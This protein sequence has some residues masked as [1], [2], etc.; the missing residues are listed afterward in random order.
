MGISTIL[1]REFPW[2][3]GQMTSQAV[4]PDE[5]PW[6]ESFGRT[7]LYSEYRS[8]VRASYQG[9]GMTPEAEANPHLNPGQGWVSRL[10]HEPALGVRVLEQMI[11]EAGRPTMLPGPVS[12]VEMSGDRVSAVETATHRIEGRFFL[13]ATELGD[14]L[15]LSGAESVV[16]AESRADT[17]EPNALDGPAEPRCQQG[18]TWCAVFGWDPAGD[19]TIAK[20]DQYERWRAFSPPGWPGPLLGFEY[21]NVQTGETTSLPLFGDQPLTWFT[22]RQIVD[23]ALWKEPQQAA[24]VVNWPQN[25]LLEGSLLLGQPERDQT[26]LDSRELTLS[27]LYWLQAECGFRGLRLRP[28]LAGTSDGLAQAPYIRESRRALTVKRVTELDVATHCHPGRD[29]TVPI[30]DSFCVGAY[31]LD[32]HPRIN[33]RPT[34]DISSLPYQLPLGAL[35]PVRVQNLIPACKNIGVT[36]IANG[37]TRLH[38]TEWAIGEAAGLLAAFC[39]AEGLVPLEVLGD[40]RER[41]QSLLVRQGMELSWPEDAALRPL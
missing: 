23:P 1:I 6:I 37:C 11:A 2:I 25:D 3:G 41:L 39:L 14:I 15:D 34:L 33:G 28:D 27:V 18:I 38:P 17:G 4:P 40:A 35:V 10:C 7:A 16:G 21:P 26:L 20:P 9:R 30:E 12:R 29:R 22:Y 19:H 24:T 8:R 5:H 31:R 13:D 36:H 32:L